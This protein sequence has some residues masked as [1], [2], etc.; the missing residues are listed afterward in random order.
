MDVA[1]NGYRSFNGCEDEPSMY[2]RTDSSLIQLD[3]SGKRITGKLAGK[4]ELKK[5]AIK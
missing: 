5:K 3:M 4:Y 1:W 2:I